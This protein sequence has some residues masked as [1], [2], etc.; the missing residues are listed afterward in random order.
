MI[1]A[2]LM[3]AQIGAVQFQTR[4]IPDTVYVGQQVTYDAVTLVDDATR[5][6][7]HANPEYTPSPVAGVT[8]YDFP[9]DTAAISD[10]LQNGT[11]LRRYLYR[12][13]LF[14]LS[15]GSYVIP[16]ATLRYTV[17]ES[18]GY[19][20][21]SR[22]A[23]LQSAADTFVAL[24]LPAAGRPIGFSGA[25]GELRDTIWT[26]GTPPRAGDTF[27]VT[28][29]VSGIGNL[30]LLPRPALKV[31][32]AALVPGAERLAW[33]S[34]GTVVRGSKEFDWIATPRVIG[35]LSI[36]AVRYDYF[37]PTTRR[38][39]AATTSLLPLTVAAAAGLTADSI[40]MVRDTIGDSPFPM[41][42]RL[43]RENALIVA[44]AASALLILLLIGVAIARRRR[45]RPS[46]S[47]EG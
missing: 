46:R 40:P 4:A 32:W 22:V 6:R 15:A 2:L 8:V 7:L 12:R 29:R 31:D 1:T 39:E 23:V 38:Y 10:V 20:S 11:H 5:V 30:N 42:V 47:D 13:A 33:D 25:V 14:P 35:E 43:A 18:D 26:D 28:V 3:F 34:T 9:F 24:A 41:L 16:P 19:L 21:H 36:P 44:I 27:V 45:G 37:N 17:P